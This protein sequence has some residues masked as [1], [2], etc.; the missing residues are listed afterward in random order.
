MMAA[1]GTE[2]GPETK[3][4]EKSIQSENKRLKVGILNYKYKYMMNDGAT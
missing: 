1:N 2:T 4:T 3:T